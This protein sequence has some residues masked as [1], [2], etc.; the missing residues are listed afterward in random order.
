MRAITAEGL[1]MIKKAEGLRLKAKYDV[2]GWAIGYGMHYYS[3]GKSVQQGDTI[4]FQNAESEFIKVLFIYA[5]AVA[6]LIT[7]TVSDNQFSALVSYAY[8]RGM[9]AFKG[10]DFLVMVNKNPNDSAIPAQFAVEWGTNQSFKTTL[11]ERRKI[12]G[13]L[14]AKG[15][16]FDYL[17]YLKIAL[18]IVIIYYGYQYFNKKHHAK[19]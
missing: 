9:G 7:S 14:Y 6:K 8:N 4:T 3:N 12:E 19:S 18:I 17:Y 2:N 10:S 1:A 15:S 13:A 16:T 5:K 11:I